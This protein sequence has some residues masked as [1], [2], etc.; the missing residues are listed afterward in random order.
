MGQKEAFQWTSRHSAELFRGE[1][2]KEGMAAF[3]GK[4]KPSWAKEE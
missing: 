1:E 2:A 3:L 4:R